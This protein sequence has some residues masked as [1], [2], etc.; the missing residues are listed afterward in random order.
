M[1]KINL[2]QTIVSIET[3][4]SIESLR[5]NS[6]KANIILARHLSM[7]FC[8]WYSDQSLSRIAAKHG[9]DNHGT[10]INACSSVDSQL[11]TNKNYNNLYQRILIKV[12]Q[13]N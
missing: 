8:R 9:K 4:V 13:I 5:G 10:V 12:K 6:R 3:G 7:Y 2:I 1:E 11:R